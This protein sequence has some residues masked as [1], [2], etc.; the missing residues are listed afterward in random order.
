MSAVT[1]RLPRGRHSLTREEVARSQRERLVR[2]MAEVMAEQG[3]AR[4]SVADIL[5]AAGVSRETFY[6][7][8]SSKEDCFMSAFEEAYGLILSATAAG[9]GSG[10]AAPP[11]LLDGV[12][13]G[14]LEALA[15]SPALARLFL[16]EVYAAGPEALARRAE[17][18]RGL[19]A[20]LATAL[21]TD[22]RFAVEALVAS[23]TA[24]VTARL[25]AGDI[26]GLRALHAPLAAF[27]RKV[28]A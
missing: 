16:V 19:V 6:Q 14:Y 20:A 7:Q 24:L 2:A 9:A 22:D 3:Y 18:Q 27:A 15:D 4:T 23:I 25:V 26:D 1:D 28:I 10:A 8:F 17:L 12:L 21:G 11:A 13:A 5:R